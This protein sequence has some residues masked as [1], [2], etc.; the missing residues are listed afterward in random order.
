MKTIPGLFILPFL[1]APVA[2]KAVEV[3]AESAIVMDAGS[4]R[5]LWEKDAESARFP[6]S[7]TK[8]MTALLL[9]ERTRPEEVVVAP[10]EIKE[11]GESSMH[12]KPWEKVKS[13]DLLYA[14]MLRSANDGS[15]AAAKHI[16]GS[17]PAFAEL[18]NQRAR[19]LGCT[20]TNFQNPNGLNDPKHVTSAHDLALMAREAMKYPEFR[21]VVGTF[22]FQIERSINKADRVM[23]SR[24]RLLKKDPTVEGIKTGYTRPAGYCFVGA[25]SRE[26]YRVITVVL[27]SGNW[28]EDTEK[29]MKYAFESFEKRDKVA[30]GERVATVLLPN[31]SEKVPVGAQ[32]EAYA[33][34]RRTDASPVEREIVLRE[35]VRAPVPRGT[36]VGDLVMR[37][38]VGYRHEVP[39]VALQDV[40]SLGI[41]NRAGQN[42]S[43][44]FV[45]GVLC[46]GAFWMRSRARRRI[47]R[48]ARKTTRLPERGV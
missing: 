15:Y 25:T 16:A 31:A 35:G 7:T 13:K 32:T 48:H 28:L 4:G 27:K 30:A 20:R 2:S 10:P 6:A 39:V 21:E 40:H 5:I 26:G 43:F 44:L 36:V 37:D 34:A 24:N 18:M 33:L 38:G 47:A 11:V 14:I 46:G 3:T 41:V 9:I 23:V 42:P 22:K 12:L 29:L 1:L 17:I 19:D 45:G 8:I